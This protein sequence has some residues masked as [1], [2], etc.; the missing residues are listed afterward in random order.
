MNGFCV[1]QPLG[2]IRWV[3]ISHFVEGDTMRTN[4]DGSVTFSKQELMALRR[5]MSEQ[6][7][8]EITIPSL[9]VHIVAPNRRR[10][11]IA[12]CVVGGLLIL[13]GLGLAFKSP[14]DSVQTKQTKYAIAR[15][16][17]AIR[18]SH[19]Y[20]PPD[21]MDFITSFSNVS[22][23]PLPPH[24]QEASRLALDSI[25]V[26]MYTNGINEYPIFTLT[27]SL[28]IVGT[29]IGLILLEPFRS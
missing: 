23:Y 18:V 24:G 19:Q 22:K 21:E 6:D 12:R 13:I 7:L 26:N 29:G 4:K 5:A 25:L 15:V 16:L 3:K 20:V 8:Q 27:I 14:N 9:P 1:S 2:S 11:M 17:D 10:R 28:G